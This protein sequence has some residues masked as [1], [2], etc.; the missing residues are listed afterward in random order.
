[1]LFSLGIRLGRF[2]FVRNAKHDHMYQNGHK[3]SLPE[4]QVGKTV[5]AL[6]KTVTTMTGSECEQE[7]TF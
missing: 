7:E 1:M 3:T 2:L 4:C 6:A 5:I